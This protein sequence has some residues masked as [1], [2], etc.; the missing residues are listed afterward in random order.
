M[1]GL[2]GAASKL[3]PENHKNV[4]YDMLIMDT[5]RGQDSTGVAEIVKPF[6]EKEEP[7]IFLYKTVGP[8]TALF[9]E[10]AAYKR[11]LT[12]DP[13][14]VFIG[15]NRF[16]TQGK[17][18][19]DSAHPFDFDNVVGAHNGTVMQSSMKDFNGY[20]EHDIDSQIIY[21]HL[22]H[23]KSSIQ[24]VWQH[25]DG[26]MA[27]VWWDKLTNQLKM[28]RNEQ[29][30]LWLAYS[31]D[32]KTVFWASEVWMILGACHRNNVKIKETFQLPVNTL[33]TFSLGEG[34]KMHHVEESIPPF[35]RK[36]VYTNYTANWNNPA[37][38][39]GRPKE[40]DEDVRLIIDQWDDNL[41][42]AYGQTDKGVYV[43]IYI[44]PEDREQVKSLIITRPKTEGFYSPKNK[45]YMPTVRRDMWVSWKN[46][47]YFKLK[48]GKIQTLSEGGFK[49]V[50]P[51]P[52]ANLLSEVEIFEGLLVGQDEWEGLV[53]G[54]CACCSKVPQW[55]DATSLTWLS[56]AD[57]ACQECKDI[58]WVKDWQEAMKNLTAKVV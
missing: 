52:V 8:A 24:E 9:D 18:D 58:S 57:Y 14:G 41:G 40:K 13:V 28:V 7:Q 16:A 35:V 27:L 37:V 43:E 4:F 51:K 46:L 2:V 47:N 1:C 12:T 30:P 48:S 39:I 29:R 25:A 26:A 20:M 22:S 45:M 56:G 44:P 11:N 21:S 53:K 15:H 19:R 6:S 31:E 50:K 5:L 3:L 42:F 32:D 10:Y 38:D 17:V 55:E 33:F 23:H 34:D 36:V 49:I 54:G